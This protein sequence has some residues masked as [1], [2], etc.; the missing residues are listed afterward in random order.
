MESYNFLSFGGI[1]LLL[2]FAWLFSAD[3][4]VI[5]WR[6]ILW[7]IGLQLFF[8]VFIFI[9]PVG[10]KIF[11]IVNDL[12][13]KILDS[14]SA[15]TRFLFGR[16]ALPPGTVNEDGETSLGAILAFQVFPAVVF[17]SSLMGA[18]YYLKIMPL[19]IRAFAFIFTKLMR[20][21][22]AESLCAS[23]N[24]FVG[25]ESPLTIK[26]HL[27]DMT[28]S[29]LCTILTACMATIASSVLALYVFMLKAQFPTIAGHLVSASVLSA[30]A[31]LVI[32]KILLPETDV[33]KTLGTDVK[34]HYERE[35]N[36]IEAIINGSMAGVKLAV[37]IGALLLAFLGLVELLDLI[38]ESIGGKVN[39]WL[40]LSVDWS[41]R[42]L[43]GYIFYP[44]TII[45][46]IPPSDAGAIARIIGERTV[47]TE[48]ESYQDL[49]RLIAAN[50]IQNP[51]SIV[52]ATYALCGFAHIAS[53]AIFVGGIST[54]APKR[55]K[56]LSELG[57]R[58]LLGATLACL[59]TACVAGMFFTKGSILLGR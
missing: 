31:A 34:P 38:L 36:V 25:I 47:A 22:G 9:I 24:I 56:D 21:S 57:F 46:G 51:R 29:E 30:P 59:M 44:F 13:I 17:F 2:I 48:V 12:V 53:L 28:R 1:F 16:L 3:R 5:N 4:R 10:T 52:V 11:L 27:D 58:A 8:G 14:A 55:I 19:L 43:L 49:A 26:P 45:I 23:S 32:S 33:P 37:G 42:G 39:L 50:G 15:G 20:L 7:G 41:L 18:L 54:L 35:N 6:I 40:G